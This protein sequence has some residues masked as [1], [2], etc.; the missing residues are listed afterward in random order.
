MRDN[1]VT[2]VGN[3]VDDPEL[4]F[5]PSGVAMAKIRF[6]VNRRYQSGGEWQ[7]ETSFFG[8]TCWRDV[9]ENVAESLQKGSRNIV[10]GSLEQRTWETQE[11]DK[12]SV[13]EIRIDDI[14]PSLRWATATVTRTPRSD[15]G[16]SG[17][18]SA[19][20]VGSPRTPSAPV[21]KDECGPDEAPL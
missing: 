7:E 16:H 14:G 19:G 6:A 4:R 21:A 12:R 20:G 5:T 11:G 2:L 17:G 9:A 13:V 3:L 18:C 8:G 15:G 1:N 10:T